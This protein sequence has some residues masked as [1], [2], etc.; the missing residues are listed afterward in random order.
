[1]TAD[2]W[3]ALGFGAAVHVLRFGVIMGALAFAPLLGISGWYLGLFAN[4]ACVLF[5]VVLV[6]VRGL[7]RVSGL[8][9]AWRGRTAALL[10][11]P[12]IIEVLLWVVP[13][14]LVERPPGFGLWALTLLLVGVN[15]ELISRVVVL[16]RMR[17]SFAPASAVALTGA[18]FGLQ[19][20]SAFATTGRGV[21]DVLLNV[22]VSAC[23]GI[24][25][26]AFQYRFRWVLPLILIHAA[27]DFTTILSANP[28]PD[29]VVAITCL[30]FLATAAVILRPLVSKKL[31]GA[32][33]LA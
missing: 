12:F 10:L 27:T 29:P 14:G 28:L 4:L 24:G 20:L 15:E 26:A 11:V 5:A 2:R 21:D 22:L 1:M 13:N 9:S 31:A 7:W 8:F 23:Y 25:L 19:H 6:T 17:R 3:Q 33:R 32:P 16:E 18:L 30:A